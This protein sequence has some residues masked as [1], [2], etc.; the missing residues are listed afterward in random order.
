VYIT[1]Q[2]KKT[3]ATA[4]RK[5]GRG[6]TRQQQQPNLKRNSRVFTPGDF[7]LAL[8][9]CFVRGWLDLLSERAVVRRSAEAPSSWL[10]ALITRLPRLAWQMHWHETTIYNAPT[11][12]AEAH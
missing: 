4:L 12:K 6:A 11:P 2:N 10:N 3:K 7:A 8:L 5:G 9:R 1:K